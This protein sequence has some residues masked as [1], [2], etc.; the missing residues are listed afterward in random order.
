[1]ALA[2]Q[3][4][5]AT[6]LLESLGIALGLGLLIGLQR[7]WTQNR[8][9]GIR[10]FPLVALLGGLCGILAGE[11]GGWITAAGLLA[12]VA[13]VVLANVASWHSGKRSIGLTTEF[14]LLLTYVIGTIVVLGYR[15]EATVCAG[16]ILVLLQGKKPLHQLVRRIGESELREVARLVLAALVILPLLPNRDMGYLGVINPFEIWLLVVLIVAIS[17]AAYLASKFIGGRKGA[18]VSGLLGG[19]ISSTATT[20]SAAR[21]SK[22]NTGASRSFALIAMIA[23]AVV[24][25]RVMIE[26]LLAG[27]T[28]GR[29]MLPPLAAITGWMILVALV[30]ARPG[31]R[32][33]DSSIDEEAPSE[34]KGA[35]VFALLYVAVLAGVAFA[36]ERLGDTGLY[37]VAA[38]SGLTDMDAITLSTS[39]LVADRHLDA[40]TGWRLILVGGCANLVFK[41]GV[42]A[43]IGSRRMLKPILL[44]FSISLAGAAALWFAW[45]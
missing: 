21:R 5:E 23:S 27:G 10:T 16:T 6:E 14:A 9:A 8:V 12:A 34:L 26:V 13:L 1:M 25:V 2:V 32:G 28:E 41:A 7:E 38:L 39:R 20:V 44:A 43:L 36:R 31:M 37:T 18:V 15:L 22:T 35:V 30:M 33:E 19:L 11:F 17:L 24:F 42:V 3:F 4:I 45:P 40:A 29:T